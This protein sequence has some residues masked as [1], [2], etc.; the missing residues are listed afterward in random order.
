M[1]DAKLKY[2]IMWMNPADAPITDNQ[3]PV[4]QYDISTIAA[5]HSQIYIRW[6]Y[7]IL[8]DRA[9]PYS[10]WNIDDVELQGQTS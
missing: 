5:G 3:W 10:G 6:S 8:S 4:L 2:Q 7:Q 9:Y 1:S